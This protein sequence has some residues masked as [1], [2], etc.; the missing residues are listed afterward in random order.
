[1]PKIDTTPD[2]NVRIELTLGG[3]STEL[4]GTQDQV[5]AAQELFRQLEEAKKRS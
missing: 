4:F 5:D 2:K 3:T 1:M